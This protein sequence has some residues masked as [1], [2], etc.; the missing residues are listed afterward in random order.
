MSISSSEGP[1][2]V[3]QLNASCT[4]KNINIL[5]SMHHCV[6]RQTVTVIPLNLQFDS[7]NLKWH[8]PIPVFE[9][10]ER[11]I[12]YQDRGMAQLGMAPWL[13]QCLTML[14]QWWMLAYPAQE[15]DISIYTT[16]QITVNILSPV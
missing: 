12:V 10:L 3:R 7:S 9:T 4:T 5:A 2:S 11:D 8:H 1:C 16:V 6:A 14:R 13:V 15:Q